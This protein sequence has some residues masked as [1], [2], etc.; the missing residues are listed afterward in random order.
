MTDPVYSGSGE[1]D[2]IY[3]ESSLP[4]GL[5][6]ATWCNA[7]VA[8]SHRCD[9]QYVDILPGNYQ[10]KVIC[11]ESGHAVGLLHGSEASPKLSRGDDR[12]GCMQTPVPDGAPLGQNQKDN[13]NANY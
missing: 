11:H 4:N 9:Q 5:I 2:I 3:K 12:L 1:T 6:G 8:N 7:P 10:K 13:I